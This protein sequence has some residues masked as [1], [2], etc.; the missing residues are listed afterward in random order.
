KV[1]K[2]KRKEKKAFPIEIVLD[3][4]FRTKNGLVLKLPE[5]RVYTTLSGKVYG[6]LPDIYY[7]IDVVIKSGRLKY[8]GR[9]FFVKRS[10]VELVKEKSR[11]L[12]EF[13]FHLNTVSDGYKIF[14]L[15]H[16][17]PENPKIYYFSEPPL[18]RERILF[19]LISGG[20]SEGILPVGGVL[21]REL[22]TLGYVKGTLER[23]FD[24]NVE[25]GIKTSSTGEVGAL[26]KLKKKLGSYL[27]LH[28]QTASTRDKKDTFWGVE[29]KSPGSLELGFRFN[30]Y[31][32]NTR[33][34]KLRYVKEFD[35]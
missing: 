27:S 16:G 13:V 31:S 29:V 7:T 34:Y 18:S 30:V 26:V 33:E 12:T 10:T 17:T 23:L 24:V 2:I 25:I 1:R 20:V 5:G 4:K 35:F 28:Y 3:V 32:D 19:R 9:E 6:K 21:A 14:L 22:K 15:I 8:F 11:K